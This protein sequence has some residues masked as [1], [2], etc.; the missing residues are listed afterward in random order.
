MRPALS[1]LAAALAPVAAAQL[2][3][4]ADAYVGTEFL[5][6][7]TWQTIADPT[8][9]DVNYVDLGTAVSQ[10]LTYATLDKFVLRADST[11]VVANGALGRNSNRILSNKAYSDS[12][13]VL[14]LQHM[15]QGCATWPAFWSLS[16][17]GPWPDGG[18]IDIIEGVNLQSGN[19]MSLHTSPGCTMPATRTMSGSVTS[20]I[21]DADYNSNQGCGVSGAPLSYGA[22]FN[23]AGGGWFAVERGNATGIRAWF[24]S[25][26]DVASVPLAVRYPLVAAVAGVSPDASWGEPYAVFPM[27]AECGYE[28]HFNAHQFVFDLTFCGDWAGSAYPTSSCPGS[29]TDLVNNNP[30]AFT[31][32]YWEVNGLW[33][34]T[35]FGQPASPNP[36]PPS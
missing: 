26:E 28:E 8:N 36:P 2:Y 29:C 35:P 18:E 4:L 1:L 12:V 11:N 7:W 3:T 6:T 14:D 34:Y 10:N 27:S 30:E 9:G 23:G 16:Q 17:T 20:T 31:E 25:R 5:S 22:D 13:A 15:P 19:L 33:I 32:A 24:W 21:C